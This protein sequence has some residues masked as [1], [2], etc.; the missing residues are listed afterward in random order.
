MIKKLP[1][2]L[3]VI[4]LSVFILQLISIIILFAIPQL[5]QAADP[6]KFI[7]QVGVGEDFKKGVGK[8]ITGTSIGEYIKA[9][10]KYAIGIVGILAAVVLMFGGILWLTAGGNAERVGNAKSWIGASLTGLVLALASYML[11]ATVNPALVQFKP[12]N[13]TEPTNIGAKK[14]CCSTTKGPF[15][16][17]SSTQNNQQIYTCTAPDV[18]FGAVKE[19]EEHEE[20][21][22]VGNF[23]NCALK[24]DLT[25]IQV[26]CCGVFYNGERYCAKNYLKTSCSRNKI[27]P[28][29]SSITFYSGKP[30]CENIP[31]YAYAANLEN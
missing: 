21:K 23:Y 16:G 6:I 11:L 2:I 20:C 12:I 27:N 3:I 31:C 17:V 26:G 22:R 29:Y 5:S 8:S 7:P 9:I 4:F 25:G 10:Y 19:C 28:K 24:E 1:K 15:D 13:P 14:S 30:E 18:S